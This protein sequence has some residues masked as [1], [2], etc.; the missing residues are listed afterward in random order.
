MFDHLNEQQSNVDIDFKGNNE[1]TPL[2]YACA[3][4]ILH[5]IE[6]LFKCANFELKDILHEGHLYI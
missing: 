4:D 1:A 3:N 6:Y 2:H 5:I